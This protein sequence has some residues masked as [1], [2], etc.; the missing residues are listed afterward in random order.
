MAG[1]LT[2]KYR[3]GQAPAPGS[4]G[5]EKPGWL[6]ALDETLYAKLE[7]LEDLARQADLPLV[8]Y[9]VAWLLSRPRIT[10]IVA[11]CRNSQQL[12]ALI[13]GVGRSIPAERFAKIDSIFPPPKPAGGMQV[14]R[15]R[16]NK[17]ALEDLES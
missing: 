8:E 12:D 14:L 11:G 16:E 4:R 1:I 9:V 2:G 5:A 17:W 3:Q 7:A 15:W 10:S 13:S 6:P